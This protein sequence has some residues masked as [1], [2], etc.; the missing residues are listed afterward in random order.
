MESHRLIGND[1]TNDVIVHSRNSADMA[2]GDSAI[3]GRRPNFTIAS[4]MSHDKREPRATA[5][6]RI[7]ATAPKTTYGKHKNKL[8]PLTGNQFLRNDGSIKTNDIG[9]VPARKSKHSAA[10]FD[11]SDADDS[12][13]SDAEPR[14][15][16]ASSSSLVSRMRKRP[17]QRIDFNVNAHKTCE[18]QDAATADN[19]NLSSSEGV[20]SADA[21]ER[22]PQPRERSFKKKALPKTTHVRRSRL[23]LNELVLVPGADCDVSFK[24]RPKKDDAM[25]AKDPISSSMRPDLRDIDSES[26]VATPLKRKAKVSLSTIRKRL[27]TPTSHQKIGQKLGSSRRSAKIT[28]T[29]GQPRQFVGDGFEGADLGSIRRPMAGMRGVRKR[30]DRD[31][32]L[33]GMQA[34]TLASGPLPDVQFDLKTSQLEF[35]AGGSP[36]PTME[37]QAPAEILDVPVVAAPSASSALRSS[38]RQVSFSDN[39]NQLIRAQLSSV[40]APRR[41]PSVSLESEDDEG[42]EGGDED[43]EDDDAAADTYL[44]E[45][46]SQPGGNETASDHDAEVS[47]EPQSPSSNNEYLSGNVSLTKRRVDNAGVTLD[48][49]RPDAPGF[50]QRASRSKRPLN[51]LNETIIDDY[52]ADDM[53]LEGVARNRSAEFVPNTSLVNPIDCQQELQGTS[54]ERRFTRSNLIH[55]HERSGSGLTSS[56]QPRSILKNSAPQTSS[57]SDRPENTAAN[58]RRNSMVLVEESR[59]FSSAKDQL[60]SSSPPQHK[61]IR[62]KSN[63]RTY[64]P[65]EVP[66]SDDFVPETSPGKVDHADTG[67]LLRRTSEAV[68]TT[69]AAPLPPRDL[70]NLT[71]TVSRDN[72]TLSQSVRRHRSLPF[73]S[74]MVGR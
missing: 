52:D 50:H 55:S 40:S 62:K 13:L 63:S 24:Q 21:G 12:P 73:Q 6:A 22:K 35:K 31:P 74:P 41:E 34:L 15:Q 57:G 17:P 59:Y 44:D 14:G 9:G 8:L 66:Y 28:A 46:E 30:F 60:T 67:H 39:V 48:F 64:A 29:G 27:C 16:I 33:K 25:L 68:W 2:Y 51:E 42:D 26:P 45:D 38:K 18:L 69:T 32:L 36:H 65:I 20:E 61:I 23:P 37:G 5:Q 19:L 53:L 58:T 1:C 47:P 71:R 10:F 7:A 49:R 3:H 11:N 4:D 43:E 54:N 70:R 56:M 72:G